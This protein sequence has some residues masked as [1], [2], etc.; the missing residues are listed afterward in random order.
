MYDEKGLL[1]PEMD[2]VRAANK[3]YWDSQKI[4]TS[5]KDS[6]IYYNWQRR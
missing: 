2:Q 1:K 3:A 4:D 6:M 5:K